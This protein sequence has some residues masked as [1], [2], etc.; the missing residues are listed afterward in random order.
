[1]YLS[2]DQSF[3]EWLTKVC[4]HPIPRNPMDKMQMFAKEL[5]EG[6]L[7][8]YWDESIL[9]ETI[10][11]TLS[12]NQYGIDVKNLRYRGNRFD[13]FKQR[14]SLISD[15]TSSSCR[16]FNEYIQ[17]R[18][19]Y[20]WPTIEI[21]EINDF[22]KRTSK[23]HSDWEISK[24]AFELVYKSSDSTS[25]FISYR[26]S[27]SSA[28]AMFVLT[29]LKVHNL[30]AFLDL[31]L[32]PGEEWHAGLEKRIKEHNYDCLIALLSNQTLQS[33]VCVKEIKWAIEAGLTI[34]PVWHNGFKFAK[35]N[36]SQI[37][38]EVLD[39]LNGRNAIVVKE[40]SASGYNTAMTE[41]L[42]RFGVT[43]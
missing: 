17:K 30:E 15:D 21:L 18:W 7:F 23:S 19:N 32:E 41:L 43:P 11:F 27:E 6:A 38:I 9:S 40:E 22:V 28:F 33:E 12:S 4:K 34:I 14:N 26:R 36:W 25:I 8:K 31:A 3:S 37:D 5:A 16:R 10:K 29:R 24:Q 13:L 42:N 2:D 35:E 20:D 39:M 1:M